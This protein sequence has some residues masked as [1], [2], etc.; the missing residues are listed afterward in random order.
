LT[1]KEYIED[2]ASKD[3]KEHLIKRLKEESTKS[4]NGLFEKFKLIEQ[5]K[6]D[7]HV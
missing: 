5:G 7:I 4:Y 6:R 2:Y 1:L 3:V